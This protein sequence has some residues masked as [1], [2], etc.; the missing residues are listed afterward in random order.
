MET[1]MPTNVPTQTDMGS[2]AN[3]LGVSLSEA[4]ETTKEDAGRESQP[5]RWIEKNRKAFA[6]YDDFVEANGVFGE[7]RQ[8]F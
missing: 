3:S 4:V 6:E 1:S 7:G 5:E 2:E 8:L